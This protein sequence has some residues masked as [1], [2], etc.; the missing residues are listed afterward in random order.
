M[1]S[2]YFRWQRLVRVT[3]GESSKN[4]L[5]DFPYKSKKHYLFIFCCVAVTLYCMYF[6]L[7]IEGLIQ[8]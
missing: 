4:S 7:I 2:W 3:A 6:V 5:C 8:R 1:N